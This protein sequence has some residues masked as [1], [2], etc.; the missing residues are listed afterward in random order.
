GRGSSPEGVVAPTPPPPVHFLAADGGER[1]SRDPADGGGEALRVTGFDDQHPPGGREA[2]PEI[3]KRR[4]PTQI[5]IEEPVLPRDIQ[6]GGVPRVDVGGAT[7]GRER[8]GA[9]P[10][11]PAC[12]QRGIALRHA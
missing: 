10:A 5:A 4:V 8:A 1:D 12:V 11:V 7:S 6:E 2:L 9:G 3:R